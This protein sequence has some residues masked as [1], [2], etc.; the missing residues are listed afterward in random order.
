MGSVAAW[1]VAAMHTLHASPVLVDSL[2]SPG[3]SRLREQS[4][5]LLEWRG[6]LVSGAIA[7]VVG[8]V[9]LGGFSDM[10]LMVA[11]VDFAMVELGALATLLAF[12]AA[13]CDLVRR[14]VLRAAERSL[15]VWYVVRRIRWAILLAGALLPGGPRPSGLDVRQWPVRPV[16]RGL[17]SPPVSVSKRSRK[18]DG[19]EGCDASRSTVC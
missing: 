17:R 13:L 10:G 12:T 2:E 9:L 6:L 7:L 8:L 18:T 4:A 11:P 1:L 19:E 16:Q 5:T 15:E 3:I 14:V